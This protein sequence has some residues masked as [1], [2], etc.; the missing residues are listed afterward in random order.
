MSKKPELA[1][2]GTMKA[3]AKEGKTFLTKNLT[4]W[5]KPY[6]M[7]HCAT[8]EAIPENDDEN[9]TEESDEV[10]EEE[11]EAEEEAAPSATPPKLAKGLTMKAT[12][13]DAEAFLEAEGRPDEDALTRTQQKKI[14]EIN[15]EKPSPAKKSR[16]SRD[17][18]MAATAKEGKAVLG[19][20]KL[21]DTRQE[22]KA[23]KSR[24]PMKK[25]TTIEASVSEAKVIY[26]DLK[27][28]G[29][30]EL[31]KRPASASPAK[32]AVKRTGT[33]QNTATEGK[34]Y[35]KRGKKSKK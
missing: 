14:D 12:A 2:A 22:T 6:L 10:E 35:L 27:V 19:S 16:L 18:T 4:E 11:E 21:A 13:K 32:P 20:E 8:A 7:E 25:S 5:K 26:N 28:S 23:R 33:M 24:T 3:T 1:R 31:R 34:A 30:R 29:G 15:A 17:N 9:G